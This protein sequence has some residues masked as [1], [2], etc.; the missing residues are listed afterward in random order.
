MNDVALGP[1]VHST[2]ML[3]CASVCHQNRSHRELFYK[4]HG[5][6]TL[7]RFLTF[8]SSDPAERKQVILATLD[9]IWESIVGYRR[10]E[11]EFFAHNGIYLVLDLLESSQDKH[12]KRHVLGVMLDILEN[13]RARSHVLEWRM[14]ADIEKGFGN[15]LIQLWNQEETEL[16]VEYCEKGFIKN[17]QCPLRGAQQPRVHPAIT[18]QNS[19]AVSE[20]NENL[21]VRWLFACLI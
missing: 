7:M 11:E 13:P 20:L 21:R 1:V 4:E 8:E 10:N 6:Q 18:S 17:L 5:V 3:I 9:C 14:K 19:R 16:G 2:A 12:M 15:L